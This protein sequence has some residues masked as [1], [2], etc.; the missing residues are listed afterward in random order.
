MIILKIAAFSVIY[1]ITVKLISLISH[2]FNIIKQYTL[3]VATLKQNEK[4]NSNSVTY[5]N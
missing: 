1:F 3:T 5:I 4:S 2:W